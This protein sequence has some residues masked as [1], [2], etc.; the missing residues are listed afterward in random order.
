MILFKVSS[1]MDSFSDFL[2]K[3]KIVYLFKGNVI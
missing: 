2:N 1:F 3:A